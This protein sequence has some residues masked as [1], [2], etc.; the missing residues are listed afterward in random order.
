MDA[1]TSMWNTNETN[2]PL[3]D[4]MVCTTTSELVFSVKPQ[5]KF[6]HGTLCSCLLLLHTFSPCKTH[7]FL[8]RSNIFEQVLRSVQL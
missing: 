6:S 3:S 5:A 8:S 7:M 1:C 2:P 4:L